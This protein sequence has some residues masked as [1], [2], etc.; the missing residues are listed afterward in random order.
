MGVI[1]FPTDCTVFQLHLDPPW[2]PLRTQ[3]SAHGVAPARNRQVPRSPFKN[4]GLETAGH[5]FLTYFLGLV[6]TVGSHEDVVG[7]RPKMP[8]FNDRRTEPEV[9]QVVGFLIGQH[10]IFG[11]AHFEVQ[12]RTGAGI[13]CTNFPNAS[14]ESPQTST[15]MPLPSKPGALI[16]P[17][18][19][20]TV[21]GST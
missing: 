14:G 19:A 20:G 16:R 4:L 2:P 12:L 13:F 8:F 9:R 5:Q 1:G 7:I 18:F 15:S 11:L 17:G 21:P 3:Q 10:L 6:I